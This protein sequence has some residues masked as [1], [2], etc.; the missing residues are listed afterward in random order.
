MSGGNGENG[1]LKRLE[2]F[3]EVLADS[4]GAGA[5]RGQHGQARG[6]LGTLLMWQERG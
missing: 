1:R 2:E 5:T 3:V 6:A 4:H